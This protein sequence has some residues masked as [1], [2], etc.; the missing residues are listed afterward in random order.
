MKGKCL[1]KVKLQPSITRKDAYITNTPVEIVR[2]C[3]ERCPYP[4][5]QCGT[6]GCDF[7]KAERKRLVNEGK[8]KVRNMRKC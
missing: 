8:L 3:T 4:R 1:G 5:A 6:E 2:I 7:F